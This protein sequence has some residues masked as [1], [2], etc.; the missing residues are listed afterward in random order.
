MYVPFSIATYPY[1]FSKQIKMCVSKK[2]LNDSATLLQHSINLLNRYAI[3]APLPTAFVIH[4]TTGSIKVIQKIYQFC[5]QNQQ[6]HPLDLEFIDG[7]KNLIYKHLDEFPLQTPLPNS[8]ELKKKIIDRLCDGIVKQIAPFIPKQVAHQLT[9]Q[10]LNDCTIE[11]ETFNLTLLRLTRSLGRDCIDR[12]TMALFD[13]LLSHIPQS[14]NHFLGNYG[15]M[16]NPFQR[17]HIGLEPDGEFFTLNLA[18]SDNSEDEKAFLSS[19]RSFY[20]HY[21]FNRVPKEVFNHR[22]FEFIGLIS[23]ENTGNVIVSP[24]Q[25]IRFLEGHFNQPVECIEIA[26]TTHINFYSTNPLLRLWSSTVQKDVFA[27]NPAQAEL[28]LFEL[29][30]YH[31]IHVFQTTQL[32][33]IDLEPFEHAIERFKINFSSLRAERPLFSSSFSAKC[34]QFEM[35]LRDMTLRIEQEKNRRKRVQERIEKERLEKQVLCESEPE[36]IGKIPSGIMELGIQFFNF[37]GM[38]DQALESFS[39]CC[40]VVF[41]D[42]S[43]RIIQTIHK[44][45]EIYQKKQL[46]SP[47]QSNSF[48]FLHSN[49]EKGVALGLGLSSY[50]LAARLIGFSIECF[51]NQ[52]ELQFFFQKVISK[53]Y[54]SLA[55]KSFF[56]ALIPDKYHKLYLNLVREIT[57]ILLPVIFK[58]VVETSLFLEKCGVYFLIENISRLL[59]KI[60]A[61]GILSSGINAAL[62]IA[63]TKKKMQEAKEL[64]ENIERMISKGFLLIDPKYPT[65]SESSSTQTPQ[66]NLQHQLTLLEEANRELQGIERQLE[67]EVTA[68]EIERSQSMLKSIEKHSLLNTVSSPSMPNAMLYDFGMQESSA[69]KHLGQLK[70]ILERHALMTSEQRSKALSILERFESESSY[71]IS[72]KKLQEARRKWDTPQSWIIERRAFRIDYAKLS[73]TLSQ[74]FP[75]MNFDFLEKFEHLIDERTPIILEAEEDDPLTGR[76]RGVPYRTRALEEAS[77]ITEEGILAESIEQ[78]VPSQATTLTTVAP[79]IHH[80]QSASSMPSSPVEEVQETLESEIKKTYGEKTLQIWEETYVENRSLI[81]RYRELRSTQP[82]KIR[83]QLAIKVIQYIEN[84][85]FYTQE[86]MSDEEQIK[87]FLLKAKSIGEMQTFL[88]CIYNLT[89][90]RELGFKTPSY[91][92]YIEYQLL[93]TPIFDKEGSIH[94]IWKQ[95]FNDSRQKETTI[96]ILHTLY[97]YQLRNSQTKATLYTT[98]IYTLMVHFIQ[99]EQPE[100]FNQF[101]IEKSKI[102]A[103][104]KNQSTWGEL[105]KSRKLIDHLITYWEAREKSVKPVVGSH[106]LMEILRN[107]GPLGKEAFYIESTS[108]QFYLRI[109][110]NDPSLKAC[111]EYLFPGNIQLHVLIMFTNNIEQLQGW[112]SEK[113][114]QGDALALLY[115]SELQKRQTLLPES[116]ILLRHLIYLERY[117]RSN[118][119]FL[120]QATIRKEGKPPLKLSDL[121]TN[122]SITGLI[123][124][125]YPKPESMPH[126]FRFTG[127]PKPSITDLSYFPVFDQQ[128]RLAEKGILT[129]M[130][131]LNPSEK[132][133][134]FLG[135]LQEDEMNVSIYCTELDF[136]GLFSSAASIDTLFDTMPLEEGK[137]CLM[138]IKRHLDHIPLKTFFPIFGWA[139]H[140]LPNSIF[141]YLISERFKTRLIERFPDEKEEIEKTTFTKEQYIK[142]LDTITSYH[143][144]INDIYPVY[145]WIGNLAEIQGKTLNGIGSDEDLISYALI[146][147]TVHHSPFTQGS[148]K[149]AKYIQKLFQAHVNR[150][151]LYQL[152]KIFQDK[153]Y[154]VRQ[155]LEKLVQIFHCDERTLSSG[156]WFYSPKGE[157]IAKHPKEGYISTISFHEMLSFKGIPKK[158]KITPF[159]PSTTFETLIDVKAHFQT[160]DNSDVRSRDLLEI[161]EK[162]SDL[163]TPPQF[164]YSEEIDCFIE[165]NTRY[166]F[167]FIEGKIFRYSHSEN[168][169]AIFTYESQDPFEKRAMTY[170]KED[171][172]YLKDQFDYASYLSL[173]SL[174]KRSKFFDHRIYIELEEDVKKFASLKGFAEDIKG[175]ARIGQSQVE[176]IVL[177]RKKKSLFFTISGS[178]AYYDENPSLF[179]SHDQE[180]PC[181]N[182]YG[183]YLRLQDDAN[184]TFVLIDFSPFSIQMGSSMLIK[185]A[186]PFFSSMMPTLLHRVADSMGFLASKASPLAILSIKNDAIESKPLNLYSAINLMIHSYYMGHQSN[187]VKYFRCVEQLQN[188]QKMDRA[189][190]ELLSQFLLCNFGIIQAD[191]SPILLK[192]T[193]LYFLNQT[194]FN[195][196]DVKNTLSLSEGAILLHALIQYRRYVEKGLI[197]PSIFSE[198]DEIRFLETS[199]DLLNLLTIKK[200]S[201][202]AN[203]ISESRVFNK[204]SQSSFHKLIEF[205]IGDQVLERLDSLHTAYP[206]LTRSRFSHIIQSF[207]RNLIRSAY[208][209]TT[210][211]TTS[212][213]FIRPFPTVRSA[214]FPLM[215]DIAAASV[216]AGVQK[217]ISFLTSN[218]PYPLNK[219]H[220]REGLHLKIEISP[221][222]MNNQYIEKHLLTFLALALFDDLSEIAPESPLEELFKRQ[223]AKLVEVFQRLSHYPICRDTT[224]FAMIREVFLIAKGEKTPSHPDKHATF[225]MLLIGRLR[226]QVH[227]PYIASYLQ[228][229]LE[230]L[231]RSKRSYRKRM[232]DVKR[233]AQNELSLFIRAPRF[234]RGVFYSLAIAGTYQGARL[235]RSFVT[236]GKFTQLLTRWGIEQTTQN[237]YLTNGKAFYQRVAPHVQRVQKTSW[238]LPL[239][240]VLASAAYKTTRTVQ[241]TERR[242]DQLTSRITPQQFNLRFYQTLGE[243]DRL[244]YEVVQSTLNTHCSQIV[245][246]PLSYEFEEVPGLEEVN[247]GARVYLEELHLD[248]GERRQFTLKNPNGFE[249]LTKDLSAL[250]E[251]CQ[252]H[253]K[254]IELV[255][256]QMIIRIT[257]KRIHFEELKRCFMEHDIKALNQR[258]NLPS[259]STFAEHV[260]KKLYYYFLLK[261]YQKRLERASLLCQRSDSSIQS[262]GSLLSEKR[263]YAFDLPGLEG[264]DRDRLIRSFLLFEG[265][266]GTLLTKKQIDRT[267]AMARSHSDRLA[268]QAGMGVGKTFLIMFWNLFRRW[269]KGSISI[270]L[271]PESLIEST[272]GFFGQQFTS[273]FG[274]KIHH[275]QINR[276]NCHPKRLHAILNIIRNTQETGDAILLSREGLS[277]LNAMLKVVLFEKVSGSQDPLLDE[278]LSLLR[279][280]LYLLNKYG[281]MTGDEAHKL[282]ER[283]VE[284]NFP[285]GKEKHL[286]AKTYLVLEVLLCRFFDQFCSGKENIQ[287]LSETIFSCTETDYHETIK[288]PLIEGVLEN[289]L[290]QI[291]PAD[292]ET[293]KEFLSNPSISMPEYV[294][295]HPNKEEI[296]L[297]R[298]FI[299]NLLPHAFA[300]KQNVEWG[301]S[302]HVRPA[303]PYSGSN[304]PE[305][306]SFFKMVYLTPVLT[307]LKYLKEG[308][309]LSEVAEFRSHLKQHIE[310]EKKEYETIESESAVIQLLQ[311]HVGSD[312]TKLS[313]FTN[314]ELRFNYHLIILYVS[315][316]VSKDIRY[317]PFNITSGAQDLGSLVA[318]FD[319]VTG[320]PDNYRT[321]PFDTKM[322]FDKSVIGRTA[323]HLQRK[324]KAGESQII[325][326]S[327]DPDKKPLYTQLIEATLKNP[328][329]FA[330]IDA[331]AFFQS[332]LKMR[333]LDAAKMVM[334][335]CSTHREEI[336]GVVFYDQDKQLKILRKTGQIIRFDE[337]TTP[338]HLRI[339]L[340]DQIHTFGSDIKQDP[341]AIGV[342][343]VHELKLSEFDQG[344]WRF[345][346]AEE[347]QNF[348]IVLSPKAHAEIREMGLSADFEG[349]LKFLKRNQEKAM[350]EDAYYADHSKMEHEI[351]RHLNRAI[352]NASSGREARR[353]FR[354]HQFRF[355]SPTC[356]DPCLLFGGGKTLLDSNEV[357]QKAKKAISIEIESLR[358]ISPSQQ[359]ESLRKLDSVGTNPYPHHVEQTAFD[360]SSRV[361][362]NQRQQ[363]IEQQ[364]VE[365]QEEEQMQ[366]RKISK[367]STLM[368]PVVILPKGKWPLKI[369]SIEGRNWMKLIHIDQMFLGWARD[370]WNTHHEVPL[371]SL[372]ELFR[373]SK[374]PAL[375][376]IAPLIPKEMSATANLIPY[377]SKSS[378]SSSITG[379]IM[380]FQTFGL[381]YWKKPVFHIL[382]MFEHNEAGERRL[383]TVGIDQYDFEKWQRK[384]QY[385]LVDDLMGIYDLQTSSIILGTLSKED[386][387]EVLSSKSFQEQLAVWTIFNCSKRIEK[388]L[389]ELVKTFLSHQPHGAIQ[390][391]S[392]A[393]EALK[394]TRQYSKGSTTIDRLLNV[395]DTS[396]QTSLLLPTR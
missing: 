18:F 14:L 377:V 246:P 376:K 261:N 352:I 20:T 201:L 264:E 196:E 287:E 161:W 81:D 316:F 72:E 134:R 146:C 215:K 31:L 69:K 326:L 26:Q 389:E 165:G 334:H 298:G 240:K 232:T 142:S 73:H 281:H 40:R 162:A 86:E 21:R 277:S 16:V 242:L 364:E 19:G 258:L 253:A 212:P 270:A 384:F 372:R 56:I 223:K 113:S 158:A 64:A 265:E 322:V 360:L 237:R 168:D 116:I 54:S 12:T 89:K 156:E 324:L 153:P 370:L 337:D 104:L 379:M 71:G 356:I 382:I 124:H 53:E 333:N 245:I 55:I 188:L 386:Q 307:Y 119:L 339:T 23:S 42:S 57:L 92:S 41:Q 110:E 114:L 184:H 106:N 375:A 306:G 345:R 340:Y 351:I 381:E 178:K 257:G 138:I 335:F 361:R 45:Y 315:L 3:M 47:V 239:F 225:K 77:S 59:E 180:Q 177:T 127:F 263:Q 395:L 74:L 67:E 102:C 10:K 103:F 126:H 95:L 310:N 369:G 217:G 285:V 163:P 120:P 141:I 309:S 271:L 236:S 129:Q 383:T 354:K 256:L 200:L 37:I 160:W 331:S 328:K 195:K 131:Q 312:R 98:L 349:L 7:F 206:A 179:L 342:I 203:S 305:E 58:G 365:V 51:A 255:L 209:A 187:F 194:L 9:G 151:S 182:L 393:Y 358:E 296:C 355:L 221:R 378:R 1:A 75:Q 193:H 136:Q 88:T 140:E 330:I 294:K 394:R 5:V 27:S 299:L 243:Q 368:K 211:T 208:H 66:G 387:D 262:I 137:K 94:P 390:E 135:L 108:Y 213:Q 279:E 367:R 303:I 219:D 301:A 11:G 226:D 154:L 284:L 288:L 185:N 191:E 25:I 338:P 90:L 87:T 391:W 61:V 234:H 249:A 235:M 385:D 176:K 199:L 109:L 205:L 283:K 251:E 202:L 248:Q 4:L 144:E 373:Y 50:F 357:I 181:A 319:V 228:G 32:Q 117:P 260:F 214:L 112:L 169:T 149:L 272:K 297:A 292:R 28:C 380:P 83:Q 275:V 100:L 254:E 295:E 371:F 392:H 323:V 186:S 34:T 13:Q 220:I 166:I 157:F 313:D 291:A 70:W 82:L 282:F 15:V 388:S 63:I 174:L 286:P 224:L 347:N 320:T 346:Q 130:L 321:Y 189:S 318:S 273:V 76:M 91:Q 276:E 210:T 198:Y 139:Y 230:G 222:A 79:Q 327:E 266:V 155:V 122:P 133:R 49:W 269:K 118:S 267:L 17:M 332:S 231:F 80:R 308:L 197:H 46:V 101:P 302:E 68:T 268:T 192:L 289:S 216:E 84:P 107:E 170:S 290:F 52:R 93:N 207:K 173:T 111:L 6:E 278:Q 329:V 22:L 218:T 359:R 30:L 35:T 300:L 24:Q 128:D 43:D 143:P 99:N 353:I 350:A 78:Q 250:S 167:K 348:M 85:F 229:I 238:Y 227:N 33:E 247:E 317:S 125:Y 252:Q 39:K 241:E 132:F 274:R 36:W 29:E 190:Q 336:Q 233:R 183:N 172:A 293:V 204:I 314:H 148:Y 44:E 171:L 115:I 38:D 164:F 374:N 65:E 62:S 362:V 2:V 8:P 175:Y 96:N 304:S 150:F 145:R 159:S 396:I 325:A 60:P 341:N 244:F 97:A 152:E 280:I 121:E 344:I 105:E 259:G 147:L 366:V 363:T 123:V 343:S 311:K 48:S